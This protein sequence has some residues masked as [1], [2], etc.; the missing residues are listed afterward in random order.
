MVLAYLPPSAVLSTRKTLERM[1]RA[2]WTFASSI[3]P[4]VGAIEI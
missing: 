1:V 2:L 4:Y 3:A